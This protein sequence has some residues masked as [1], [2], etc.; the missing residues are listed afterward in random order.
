MNTTNNVT[1]AEPNAKAPTNI[2]PQHMAAFH[3]LSSGM[4]D[5]FALFS[6]FVNGE[7]SSAIVH[8]HREGEGGMCRITPLFVA[9]TDGM[10]LTDHDGIAATEHG[11]GE[12]I[13]TN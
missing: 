10:V 2:L 3:A 12:A 9:V 7:P 5:N 8:V 6:C 11:N 1:T 13:A 4:F